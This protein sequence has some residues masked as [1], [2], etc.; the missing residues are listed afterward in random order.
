M[1]GYVNEGR[2]CIGYHCSKL[3]GS[4]YLYRLDEL[5]LVD[6]VHLGHTYPFH[7]IVST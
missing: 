4:A 7:K 1:D 6:E 5:E 3:N 2:L